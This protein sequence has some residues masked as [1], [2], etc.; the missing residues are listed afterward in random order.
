[1]SH[2]WLSLADLSKQLG[3]DKR[4]LEK[5]VNR[6]RLPG[7]KRDGEWQ[8]H[9]SEV[10]SWLEQELRTLS[11]D[12]LQKL[13][14]GQDSDSVDPERPLTSL[15]KP[16]LCEIPLEARTKRSV[17]ESLVEVAGRTWHVWEPADVLKAVRERD[18]MLSTAFPGGVAVP[19]PRQ[20]MHDALGESVVAFGRTGNGIPFGAPDGGMTDL[21]FLVLC[22]DTK[23]HLQVLARLSRMF[24]QPHFLPALR[25]AIDVTDA[26]ELIIETEAGV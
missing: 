15:L 2:N 6:G 17:F 26:Y 14:A 11:G 13:E 1:M 19:H 23:T 7:H 20:P 22:R 12:Q 16:E 8:F 25:E 24:Q 18:E 5:L 10:A 4:D 3:R 21:F 9:E